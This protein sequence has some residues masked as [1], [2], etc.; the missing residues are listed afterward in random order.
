LPGQIGP[1]T[2]LGPG[3]TPGVSPEHGTGQYL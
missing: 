3:M 1:G 2:G